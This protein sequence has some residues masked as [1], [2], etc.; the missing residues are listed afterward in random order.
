MLKWTVLARGFFVKNFFRNSLFLSWNLRG[1]MIYYK[2]MTNCNYF[3]G[4]G[5]RA[6]LKKGRLPVGTRGAR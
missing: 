5:T 4:E 3:P 6:V 2:L 1:D